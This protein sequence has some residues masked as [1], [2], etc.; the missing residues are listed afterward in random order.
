MFA[1]GEFGVAIGA[2]V[3][4]FGMIF[5]VPLVVSVLARFAGRLPLVMRYAAGDAA[6]HRTRTVP[7]VAAVG[8]TVAGV[9]ALGIAN[10]SD[11][12]ENR[13]T[14]E[15]TLAMGSAT[16]GVSADYDPKTGVAT[17]PPDD[18]WTRID[19]AIA[20]RLPGATPQVLRGQRP[21]LPDGDN[22]QMEL[23]RD[24]ENAPYLGSWGGA[25]SNAVTFVSDGPVP[26]L[27]DVAASSAPRSWPPPSTA[28]PWSSPRLGWTPRRSS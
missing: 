6:R 17:L 21:E 20:E 19:A 13:E 27:I 26:G 3:S 10:S 5:V 4:V 11:E 14:Y 16:V 9:V 7:A 24:D 15:P 12:A 2:V 23:V 8:A 25:P 1:N 22:L 28:G 18:V